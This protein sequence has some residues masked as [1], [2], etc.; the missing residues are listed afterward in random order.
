MGRISRG[1]VSGNLTD[2]ERSEI[3]RLIK[4]SNYNIKKTAQTIGRHQ[5]TVAR[6]LHGVK[7]TVHLARQ[8]F[9]SQAYTLA[10]RVVAEA[11]VDQSLEILDRTEVLVRK[12]D[13]DTLG[14][15]RA[16]VVV[17]VG[18]PG[19]PALPVPAQVFVERALA[20]KADA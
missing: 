18:M 7:S 4:D 11:D 17:C 15:G 9:D 2:G 14:G 20:K 3:L 12:R 19:Q 16:S 13:P 6:F 5:R 8:Y 10:K 1:R